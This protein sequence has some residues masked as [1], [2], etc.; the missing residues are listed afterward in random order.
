MTLYPRHSAP[1]ETPKSVM[2]TR[3]AARRQINRLRADLEDL[4]EDRID[5][6]GM[7]VWAVATQA[8]EAYLAGSANAWQTAM[9]E[10]EAATHPGMDAAEL[11]ETIAR[12]SE[13]Y[14]GIVAQLRRAANRSA[15]QV[16]RATNRK[17]ITAAVRRFETEIAPL[18]KRLRE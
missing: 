1:C 11:S 4:L 2:Q 16:D 3:Q 7:V 17:L 12:R 18:E 5:Y 13:R 9:L 8:A 14:H 10:Q 6:T 15:L